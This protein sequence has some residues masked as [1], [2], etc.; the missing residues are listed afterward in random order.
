MPLSSFDTYSN[1]PLAADDAAAAV[2]FV[3]WD[4]AAADSHD[5]DLAGFMRD[6]AADA[7]GRQLL[8]TF[9]GNSPYLAHCCL[10]KPALLARLWRRGVAATFAELISRLNRDLAPT[11]PREVLAAE[12]RRLKRGVALTVAIA[13]IAGLWPVDRVM[14]ALSRFAEGALALAVRHLLC[15]AMARGQFQA[16]AADDPARD[17][18]FIVLAMGKL[19]AGELNYSSD[20]DVVM[21][22]DPDKARV[23]GDAGAQ[24]LFTRMAQDLVRLMAERTEDGYVF[25]TDLRLRPDPGSTPPALSLP[26]ALAYYESAGQ[27]WERA[28]LIRARPVAGDLDAG[29]AFLAALTPFLWRKHL[30]FAAIQDIHSIKRQIHAQRGGARIAVAGH[31]IKLGRGGIREI[32]FFAQTQQLIWGGREPELRQRGTIAALTALAMAG[33]ISLQTADELAEAYGFLRRVEHRLQM[34][35]DAQTHTIPENAAEV[36]RL[37]VFLGFDTA[38]G[39]TAA[40]TRRLE[41]VEGHYA[42]LF[43]E[44]PSLAAPGN[45]VFTGTEDDPETL[46]TLS[47]LGFAEPQ[48]IASIV[49]AWHH[50]RYRATRSQRARELL[51]E[52]VP[53]LLRSFGAAAAPDAAFIRFDHFLGRLPAG[54]QLFSLLYQNPALLDLLAELMGAAP[55]LAETMMQRPGVL[56]AVLTAGFFDPLPPRPALGAD[57]GRLLDRTHHAEEVLDVAR[58]WVAERKFQIGIQVLRGRL[59]GETAGGAFADVAETALAELLPRVTADFVRGYGT[60]RGGAIVVLGLGKLGSREMTFASDLDLILVY[61]APTDAESTGGT[62]ALAASTYYARLSQRFINALTAATA[63]GRLYDVDMRLRPSGTAGP[64][65]SSFEAFHRY[66]RELAWTWEQMA[67]TRARPV[68]GNPALC[69]RVMAEIRSVLSRPRDAETLA[70]DV[71]TMRMRIADAHRHPIPF[72]VKHR[73]GGMVDIEFIAQY[74]QLRDASRADRILHPNTRAALA[75]LATAGS[76]PAADAERLR[77]ALALWRNVQSLLKLTAVEPFDESNTPVAVKDLIARG[78]GTIDFA[79]LARDMDAT[80]LDAHQLF[81]RI[82]ETAAARMAEE[83]AP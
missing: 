17:S 3:H 35:D 7:I 71:V 75:A 18:G 16:G 67:L 15:D 40:L 22:F 38:D 44:A 57:L 19:G 58:R 73:N 42:N 28:A 81:R 77:Q 52:L 46:R 37:A 29:R 41:I 45:L 4:E 23:S 30:D 69:E 55:T 25:R 27:N 83:R 78:A 24:A 14:G 61:D 8:T 50:G 80:A 56:D 72:D 82:V 12:L 6:L 31:N 79:A 60:I 74:L 11:L 43:E 1:L 9:F 64:V 20:I 13:D 5:A 48:T 59:D 39:F 32:E 34:I 36:R 26:A 76:L 21:L 49:R 70:R 66:H 53:I 2:G 62:Q 33:H 63:E 54:V 51:T 65:A 10:R 47:G 68:A